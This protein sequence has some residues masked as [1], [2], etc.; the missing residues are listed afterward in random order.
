MSSAVFIAA[1]TVIGLAVATGAALAVP[2]S[3]RTAVFL[4]VQTGATLLALVLGLLRRTRRAPTAPPGVAWCSTGE[5]PRAA[6]NGGGAI[7]DAG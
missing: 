3:G 7:P 1:C 6:V 2:R 4:A 5:H